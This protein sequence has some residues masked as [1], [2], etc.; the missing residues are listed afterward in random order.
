VSSDS[1]TPRPDF[2]VSPQANE[3]RAARAATGLTQTAAARL[4]QSTRRT[5]QQWESPEG[6]PAHR[7]M[8]PGLWELFCMKSDVVARRIELKIP[9]GLDYAD[10]LLARDPKTLELEFETQ[11][12]LTICEYNAIDLA[13]LEHEYTM[14]ELLSSWYRLHIAKGGVPD[15]VQ[16]KILA[17]IREE[18]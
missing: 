2:H 18:Q 5:W 11:P 13:T 6:T 9:P 15:S 4:V 17:E 1:R 10:L 7:Y 14:S 3:I 12:L 16:E 8:H